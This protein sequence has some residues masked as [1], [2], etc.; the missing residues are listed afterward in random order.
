[1]PSIL[2]T[3]AGRRRLPLPRLA[4]AALLLGGA[5][6]LTGCEQVAVIKSAPVAAGFDQKAGNN[7]LAAADAAS[8]QS[9]LR[10]RGQLWSL[11]LDTEPVSAGDVNTASPQSVVAGRGKMTSLALVLTSTASSTTTGFSSRGAQGEQAYLEGIIQ[12]IA[13]A[14][15][16]KLTSIRVDVWFDTGHH[17]TLTWTGTAGFVYKVLDGK[18]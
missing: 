18:P 14:G 11:K 1:M 12:A 2:P 10:L 7:P 6:A 15:Y 16:I 13:N 4:A 17:S 9:A 8:L 5:L 3:S